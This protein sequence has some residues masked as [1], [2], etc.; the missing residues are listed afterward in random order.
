MVRLSD[1]LRTVFRMLRV[2]GHALAPFSPALRPTGCHIASHARD[3]TTHHAMHEL[4]W[5]DEA[6]VHCTYDHGVGCQR[7]GC[8]RPFA[9]AVFPLRSLKARP[10]PQHAYSSGRRYPY[11]TP[12]PIAASEPL[13]AMTLVVAIAVA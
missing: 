8:T 12:Q 10:R 3:R 9:D 6:M 7:L 4:T 11:P 5:A 13:P 1:P 2:E